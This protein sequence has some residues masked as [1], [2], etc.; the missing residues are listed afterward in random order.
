MPMWKHAHSIYYVRVCVSSCAKEYLREI[1]TIINRALGGE[2]RNNFSLFFI[3]YTF[4]SVT[5]N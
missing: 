1:C 2:I 3:L 4:F 5:I